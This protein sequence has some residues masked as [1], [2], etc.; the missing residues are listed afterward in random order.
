MSFIDTKSGHTLSISS[1]C[2]YCG[3]SNDVTPDFKTLAQD[4]GQALAQHNLQVVYG[5]GHVGLMGIIA[6]SALKAG[7]KVIGIIPE[8]IRKMEVQH[9]G[10]TELHVVA[11]MHTRKRMMVDRSDAFV[12]L[13]GG[14]GTLDESFEILTWKKLNLHNKPVI[15]FNYKGYWAPLLKLID[16]TIKEGFSRP[17]DAALYKVVTTIDELFEVLDS[18][19]KPPIASL[20]GRI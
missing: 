14:L 2:V 10:L 7:A 1:V 19:T 4:L 13:P 6:D 16:S 9:T 18:E 12:I 11:D 20:T 8:H 17:S 3:A 5:G 15:I